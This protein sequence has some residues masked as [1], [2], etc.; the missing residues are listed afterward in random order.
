MRLTASEKHQIIP[1]ITCSELGIKR[2][3]QEYRIV[4]SR[5]YKWY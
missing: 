5:F 3:L 1:E 2:T 4:R